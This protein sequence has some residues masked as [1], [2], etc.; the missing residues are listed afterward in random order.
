MK[1]AGPKTIACY[2]CG[3]EFGTT[4]YSIHLSQCKKKYKDEQSLLA[5]SEQKKL[6]PEP[7]GLQELLAKKKPTAKELEAYN[8][9]A[10]DVYNR[11]SLS[12]CSGCGRTFKPE[13]LKI[14]L[15]S[16]KGAKSQTSAS[17]SYG[18]STLGSELGGG[19]MKG[20]RKPSK[21]PSRGPK[22]L[23][24]YICGKGFMKGSMAIHLSQ[25][26]E[27]FKK[28]SK[29]LGIKRKLPEEPDELQ[30]LL[31]MDSIPAK[32]LEEYNNKASR[33]FNDAGLMKCPNCSRTFNPDSLMT[34]MKS[35]N[36]K[37]GTDADPFSDPKKKKQ[38]RPQGIM[39]YICGKEYFSKSI[40]IHLKSCKEAWLREEKLKPKSKR[41][42]LPEPPK[43]FDD[44][45]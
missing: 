40:D 39:C 11:V 9:I 23:I 41:R 44:I 30:D 5:K 42:P 2:V 34:H 35:C 4:S 7:E 16:C 13:S 18:G 32:M 26:K 20:G 14:H 25:C 3:R 6:P 1:K 8:A 15:K 21:S 31:A 29:N 37:Y 38:S 17:S 12:E 24:C 10:F 45:V 36:A 28:E 19:G 27:K 43:N 22:A 33:S